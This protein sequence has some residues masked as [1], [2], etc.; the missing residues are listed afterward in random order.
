VDGG[1]LTE[2]PSQSSVAT[3]AKHCS[4]CRRVLV[5]DRQW[6]MC[7]DCQRL[8]REMSKEQRSKLKGVLATQASG[9][10]QVDS[11]RQMSNMPGP[12]SLFPMFS[13]PETYSGWTLS[14]LL[15]WVL[16]TGSSRVVYAKGSPV[17]FGAHSV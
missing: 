4:Q 1:S 9:V 17:N 5:R 2:M 11:G 10:I 14:F 15:T 6:R 7:I 12:V 8:C 13:I 3:D 16:H